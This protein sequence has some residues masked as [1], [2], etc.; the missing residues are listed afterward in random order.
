MVNKNLKNISIT[1]FPINKDNNFIKTPTDIE[2]LKEGMK[3]EKKNLK[4]ISK[5]NKSL[6]DY[7]LL[8]NCLKNHPILYFLD[9][10]AMK[11]IIQ[12]M[13][14]YES[15]ENLEIFTQGATPWFFLI[16]SE[17]TCDL[18]Y[19]GEK[20]DTKESGE[21][22][23]DLSLIYD[24]NRIYTVKTSTKCKFWGLGR[25]NFKKI[26]ELI[27]NVTFDEKYNK[28]SSLALF[29]FND[30]N[31]KNKIIYNLNKEKRNAGNQ[32]I[33]REH[34]TN[35][36]YYIEQGQVDIKFDDYVID[37][38]H[39]GDYFGEL[40]IFFNTNRIFDYVAKDNCFIYSLPIGHMN[41]ISDNYRME[42]LFSLLK[43][44]FLKVEK[45][46]NIN[47][48]FFN[49]IFDL[50]E[51]QYFGKEQII[52]QKEF[53]ISS[54]I[55]IPIEGCLFLEEERSLICKRGDLLFGE[56]LFD[57]NNSPINYNIKCKLHSLLLLADTNQVLQR[58]G[59]TFK[60]Y[61]E[62][63]SPINQLKQ[64]KLFKNLTTEKINEIFEKIKIKKISNGNNL[65]NQG[66]NGSEFFIIK[67]G[68]FDM[69]IDDKYIRSLN[70]NEYFG[71]RALFFNE[72]N[73]ETA[74]A[75]GDC[76]VFYLEKSDFDNIIKNELKEFLLNRLYLQDDKIQLED[77]YFYK[78]LGVGTYGLVSL[79][80]NKKNNYFYAI[81][82]ISKK[83]ILS[84]K[85]MN[86]IEME[87]SILLKIDHP[88]IVKLVKTLKDE[89]YI[90]YL[91]DYLKGKELF[92]V[93]RD[94]GLLNKEQAQF[95]IASIILAVNYLHQKKIIFRDI[96]PENIMVLENG[97]IKLIDFGT[98]KE[99]K[100]KT[101]SI[102]G[103]PHYM[104]PE[105]I[106]GDLYSFEIDYWS[107]GIC[108][109]EFC[110]G[111]LPFGDNE[112]DPLNIYMA[113]LNE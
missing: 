26:L 48:K 79:V 27:N 37:T 12:Q 70:E 28:T 11:E 75:K 33:K 10:N 112:E 92:S 109:Y 85:L 71:E 111:I 97:Y 16:L 4:T 107:I 61:I 3:E 69:Y 86:N 30:K 2:K 95:Y 52:L 35:C 46:K 20:F 72:K 19:N 96:K 73:S 44:A 38:L 14:Q 89:K 101:N 87:K 23:D 17:G 67:K 90:Y 18:Y 100:D 88:F 58:I 25:K 66:E 50:F 41:N 54:Y 68:I 91:M 56:Y 45:F 55:I 74:K 106:L 31:I 77:L 57:L 5:Q 113:V 104:A 98:A 51:F 93:I 6:K 82:N 83:Q 59:C 39:E 99:L 64:V 47:H 21:C 32:I 7:T 108:L 102:I 62:K 78:S 43:A 29:S 13:S 94:I 81:K 15:N 36:L 110:C 49:E 22:L 8:E 42:I 60:D 84:C 76:E 9:K 40:S 53:L 80:K 63:Y 65:V 105:V 24:C 103:T 1:N 34:I